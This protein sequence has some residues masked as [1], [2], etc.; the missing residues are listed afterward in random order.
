MR[1]G[2]PE[3]AWTTEGYDNRD[4]TVLKPGVGLVLTAERAASSQLVLDE[5][6]ERLDGV[7]LRGRRDPGLARRVG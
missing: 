6:H 4:I 1:D 2:D 7:V 5:P 3:T